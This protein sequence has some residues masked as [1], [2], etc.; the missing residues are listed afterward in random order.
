MSDLHRFVIE[1][2]D[3]GVATKVSLDGVELHGVTR[4]EFQAEPREPNRLY[5]EFIPGSIHIDAKG[6]LIVQGEE[7]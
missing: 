5:L 7:R 6:K 2:D 1:G 4:L 3:V